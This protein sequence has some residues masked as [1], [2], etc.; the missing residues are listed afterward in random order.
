MKPL[1]KRKSSRKQNVVDV[2]LTECAVA[3]IF[4]TCE[5]WITLLDELPTKDF[6]EAIEG[7]IGDISRHLPRHLNQGLDQVLNDGEEDPRDDTTADL[8]SSL[9]TFI[10]KL[11]AFSEISVQKYIDLQKSIGAAKDRLLGWT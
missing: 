5:T 3:P 6:V 10:A 8:Q 1:K 11:E 9:M 2:T 7:L 4:T